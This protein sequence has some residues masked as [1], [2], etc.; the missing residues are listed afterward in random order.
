VAGSGGGV[1][2]DEFVS[3]GIGNLPSPPNNMNVLNAR[4]VWTGS[5]RPDD[6]NIEFRTDSTTSVRTR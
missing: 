5:V 1:A 6:L 4:R 3:D 2:A